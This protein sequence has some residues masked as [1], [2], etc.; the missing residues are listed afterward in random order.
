MLVPGGRVF[1]VVDSPYTGPWRVLADSYERRKAV[2]EP[3]PGLVGDYA[4]FLSAGQD[5]LQHPRFI[6]PMD[7]D[8]LAR[9]CTDAG[10]EILGARF[11][12]GG[13]KHSTGRD[14]AG[15]VAR[16]N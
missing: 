7:P 10:F 5:P 9:V 3:W 2:G 1:L 15:V 16:K 13:T 8:I 14:H 6:N 11:L 12:Q 4:Q